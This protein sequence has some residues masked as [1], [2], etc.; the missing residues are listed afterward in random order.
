MENVIVERILSGPDELF[1]I[2]RRRVRTQGCLDLHG[3]NY[4]NSYLS[5]DATRM[6]C[7]FSAPD[8]ESVRI[9]FRQAEVPSRRTWSASLHTAQLLDPQKVHNVIVVER[10]FAEPVRFDDLQKAEDAARSCMDT[11]SVTFLHTFLSIDR[12]RMVCFYRAPDAESVRTVQRQSGL[13]F[14]AIWPAVG[15]T[16]ATAVTALEP[17]KALAPK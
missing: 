6:T 1:A 7:Q 16:P 2:M 11:H 9:A 17:F 14:D 13:P 12:K 4:E 8:A 5:P 3:V 15:Y 10:S